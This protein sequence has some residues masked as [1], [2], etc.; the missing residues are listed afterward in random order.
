[1][2]IYIALGVDVEGQ[3]VHPDHKLVLGLWPG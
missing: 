3:V 2:N 1:M